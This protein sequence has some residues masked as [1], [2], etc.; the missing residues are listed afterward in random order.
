ME[1]ALES[2]VDFFRTLMPESLD[3]LDSVV[4]PE[5]VFKDPFND[6]RGREAL[7]RIFD[8]MFERLDAPRFE[9]LGSGVLSTD[10][11]SAVIY[12]RFH[13]HTQRRSWSFDFEGTSVVRFNKDGLCVSHV[14]YWDPSTPIYS[15]IPLFGW[16]LKRIRSSLSSA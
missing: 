5:V 9:I 10:T 14:D 12:W 6:V 2:Y 4:A 3:R 11:R 16:L 7:R 8:D 13:A 15:K 1:N